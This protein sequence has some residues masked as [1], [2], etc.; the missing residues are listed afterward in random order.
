QPRLA[1]VPRGAVAGDDVLHPAAP[2][3]RRRAHR[4]VDRGGR[5]Q[6]PR[7]ALPRRKDCV[8]VTPASRRP[9]RRRPGAS[10]GAAAGRGRSGRRG[11][12][13][14]AAF[15]AAAGSLNNCSAF[16]RITSGF[17]AFG[18]SFFASG[19]RSASAVRSTT[20][21]GFTPPSLIG[22]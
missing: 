13:R 21:S 16:S 18:A 1:V 20:T 10:G 6:R 12:R 11:R 7:N 19:S 14:Y 15:S 17:G 2:A 9:D 5:R 4:R 3:Q 22:L 8:E